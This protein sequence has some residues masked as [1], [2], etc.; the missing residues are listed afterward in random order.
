[1]IYK[2]CTSD[3]GW[4]CLNKQLFLSVHLHERLHDFKSM[5]V[6]LQTIS[7]PN[8]K[9]LPIY[10]AISTHWEVR[11]QKLSCQF[12]LIFDNKANARQ[13]HSCTQYPYSHAAHIQVLHTYMC[14]SVKL[15]ICGRARSFHVLNKEFCTSCQLAFCIV[16]ARNGKISKKSIAEMYLTFRRIHVEQATQTVQ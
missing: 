14:I 15:P 10:A 4:R 8:L 1:M 2:H 9:E 6:S 16:V 3:I 13:S 7:A 12:D 5:R 11:S